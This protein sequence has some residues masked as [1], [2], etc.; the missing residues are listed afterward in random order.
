LNCEDT[1]LLLHANVDGELDLPKSLELEAHVKTCTACAREQ[2][3]LRTL[4]A[5]FSNS[6]LYYDAPGRLESRIKAAVRNARRA[7]YGRGNLFPYLGWAAA[8]V[9]ALL[10]ISITV[11]GV[12]PFGSSTSELTAREVIDDHL[13]S[14]TQ[15]HLTDVLASNQHTVKPWFDGKISF[16]PPVS[17]FTAQGFPLIGGRLDYL[18]NRPAAAVVYRRRQHIINLFIAPAPHAIDTSPVSRARA[19]YS[20]IEWSKSGMN[21][22]AVSSLNPSELSQ[23]AQLVRK[24]SR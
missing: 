2:L 22:W 23:F 24:A 13:R 10:L 9:A 15:N 14:L 11:R 4:R 12:L 19:G 7:E 8:A 21:Y 17:D 20:V 1:R 6:T 16:A 5:A 3:T 18:D